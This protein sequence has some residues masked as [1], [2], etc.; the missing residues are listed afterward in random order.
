VY[1]DGQDIKFF[2]T[3]GSD[4]SKFQTAVSLIEKIVR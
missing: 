2:Q 3:I 4:Q 1:I